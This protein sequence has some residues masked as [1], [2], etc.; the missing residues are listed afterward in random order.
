MPGLK[1]EY[2]NNTFQTPNGQSGSEEKPFRFTIYIVKRIYP[3]EEMVD[4]VT[5][6]MGDKGV[7]YKQLCMETKMLQDSGKPLRRV[8]PR[9][10]AG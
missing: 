8:L 2:E 5:K 9:G 10:Q 3:F 7:G 1:E 4:K 6:K